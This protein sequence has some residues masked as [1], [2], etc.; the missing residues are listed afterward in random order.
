MDTQAVNFLKMPTNKT[1][2]PTLAVLISAGLGRRLRPHTRKTPKSLLTIGGRPILSFLFRALKHT[3]IKKVLIVTHHLEDQII[4]YAKQTYSDSFDIEF[5]H[6]PV[7]DGSAGALK[8]AADLIQKQNIDCF[9]ICATDYQVPPHYLK[10]LITFHQTGGQDL[11]V[12]MRTIESDS[13]KESNLTTMQAPDTIL[14]IAEKPSADIRNGRV[15]ASYLLYIVPVQ[16]LDYLSRLQLSERGE[17]E[18]PDLINMMIT[19]NFHVR[20]YLCDKFA[21]WEKKYIPANLQ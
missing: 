11:S 8:S 6:Q 15:A 21:E 14:S 13:V 4:A 2:M 20:G 19:D 1:R 3:D 10:D 7:L 5:C 12:G 16:M 17:Y 9:L 18:L